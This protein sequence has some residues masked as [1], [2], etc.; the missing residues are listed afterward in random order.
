MFVESM[1]SRLYYRTYSSTNDMIL[2]LYRTS[3]DTSRALSS[4][5]QNHLLAASSLCVGV[6]V[7][8]VE[9]DRPHIIQ[10][11][12]VKLRRLHGSAV[13]PTEYVSRAEVQTAIQ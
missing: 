4:T 7:V 12:K 9:V 13:R 3:K 6:V 1:N 5:L 2:A 8:D 11:F 10:M